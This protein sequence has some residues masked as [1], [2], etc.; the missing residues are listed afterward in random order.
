MSDGTQNA[1]TNADDEFSAEEPQLNVERNR[2]HLARGVVDNPLVREAL[3]GMRANYTKAML[4]AKVEDIGGIQ[5]AKVL[6]G[7]LDVF[8]HHFAEIIRT[9]KLASKRLEVIAQIREHSSD[10]T[11]TAWF[12]GELQPGDKV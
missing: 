8:E 5:G 3:D 4:D 2:A 10:K 11:Q 1:E 7:Q 6:L 9:G 12:G